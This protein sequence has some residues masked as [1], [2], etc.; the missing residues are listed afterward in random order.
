MAHKG[1]REFTGDEISNITIGQSGFD[2]LPAGTYLASDKS[3]DY[4][5]AIK[6][7]DGDAEVKAHTYPNV[8]G[9]DFSTNGDYATGSNLTV[10]DGDMIYG[11]FDKITVGAS[12]YVLAYRGR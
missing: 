4:W 11:A 3:I 10:E 7:I 8:G 5:I 1:V 2:I 12:D 6:A 9:D